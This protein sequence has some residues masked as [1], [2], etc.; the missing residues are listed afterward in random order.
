MLLFSMF[1]F[2][3]D[4]KLLFKRLMESMRFICPYILTRNKL[5]VESDVLILII[6]NGDFTCQDF[7]YQSSLFTSFYVLKVNKSKPTE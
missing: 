7:I 3:V 6:L 5:H 2:L 4:I 1:M